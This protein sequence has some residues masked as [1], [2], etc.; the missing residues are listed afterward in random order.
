MGAMQGQVIVDLTGVPETLLMTLYNRAMEAKQPT[1]MLRDPL[2]VDL[3]K[4]I[5]YPFVQRFGKPDLSH[6]LRAIQ[7]DAQIRKFLALHPSGMVVAL[8]EGLET[9]F[10]RIDNGQVHWLT[11]DLPEVIDLRRRLLPQNNRLQML[12]CSALDLSWAQ[13]VDFT[14]DI[15]I[16]AQGLL[17]YFEP[18]EA[19]K[20]LD[21]IAERFPGGEMLFDTIPRWARTQRGHRQ[22]RFYRMP[23]QPWGIDRDQL[24]EITDMHASIKDMQILPQPQGR[25]FFYGI[26]YP[27]LLRLPIIMNKLPMT[28]VVRFAD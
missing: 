13:H 1:G 12:A 7:F 18:A 28:V 2:S 4:S 17:M 15:L 8:G 5:K 10:W 24:D 26:L 9:Q 16:V 11:V 22:S 21:A 27:L 25:G 20:L 19:H 14:Q 3:L 23:A 6:V